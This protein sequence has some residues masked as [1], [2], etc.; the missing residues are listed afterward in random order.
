MPLRPGRVCQKEGLS[1][2]I[3]PHMQQVGWPRAVHLNP[4]KQGKTGPEKGQPGSPLL[5]PA[6]HMKPHRAGSSLAP[7]SKLKR[8]TTVR[9][10]AY[11]V[12]PSTKRKQP[13]N[14]Q[15]TQT[16]LR[17]EWIRTAAGRLSLRET[18]D[19]DV[20]PVRLQRMAHPS[21]RPATLG[22]GAEPYRT[23]TEPEAKGP[24]ILFVFS[25]F[26][27]LAGFRPQLG[28]GTCPTAPA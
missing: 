24:Y 8:G 19:A 9:R 14:R 4:R 25:F 12:C 6:N 18:D 26:L 11:A 10:R 22:G 1:N 7:F 20:T 27:F 21:L 28:P 2:A 3:V 17:G 16:G 5:E 15:T 13:P 23:G